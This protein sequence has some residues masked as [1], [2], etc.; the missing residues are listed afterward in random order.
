MRYFLLKDINTLEVYLS[1]ELDIQPEN[2]LPFEV[3]EWKKAKFDQ[4]PNPTK[5]E[6][7]V[8]GEVVEVPIEVALWKIRFVL[9]QMGLEDIVTTAMSQ[10]PEPQ[11]TAADYIWNYG[12]AIDRHSNTVLFIQSALQMTDI[13]VDNIFISANGIVL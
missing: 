8:I 11:K 6:E 4:F 2:S 3:C 5:I 1:Q 9:K 12:N 7:L 10:L 13:E